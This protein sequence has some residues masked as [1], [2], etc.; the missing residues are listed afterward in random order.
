MTASLAHCANRHALY[1]MLY[2]RRSLDGTSS[3]CRVPKGTAG[4]LALHF[5][6]CK[7]RQVA[8]E[9]MVATGDELEA[10]GMATTAWMHA[11]LSPDCEFTCDPLLVN[12]HKSE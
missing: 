3:A 7:D 8:A 6:A 5:S 4:G 1:L 9:G 2:L 10:R 11:V 12:T